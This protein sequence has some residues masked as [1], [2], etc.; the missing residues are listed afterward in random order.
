[1]RAVRTV[2]VIDVAVGMYRLGERGQYD[3]S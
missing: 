2:D 3:E 1:V